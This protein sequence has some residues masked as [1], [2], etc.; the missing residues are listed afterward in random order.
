MIGKIN[1]YKKFK[2]K[3][4]DINLKLNQLYLANYQKHNV[5]NVNNNLISYKKNLKIY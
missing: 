2:K 1:F 3:Q 4:I 5:T